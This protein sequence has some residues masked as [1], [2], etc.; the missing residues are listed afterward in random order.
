MGELIAPLIISYN[1]GKIL[2][3]PETPLLRYAPAK[4]TQD[5]NYTI[6][7]Y[8]QPLAPI[9][10]ADRTKFRGR[11]FSAAKVI[12]RPD[13][14][15]SPPLPFPEFKSQK[16]ELYSYLLSLGYILRVSNDIS[17]LV[18]D[19]EEENHIERKERKI[20]GVHF[21]SGDSCAGDQARLTKVIIIIIIYKLIILQY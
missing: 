2:L 17:Q 9:F 11:R 20:L 6:T 5:Y 10:D 3:T 15:S 8:I 12:F 18:V 4:S 14:Q 16:G 13:F 1:A 21:R 19:W 7:S